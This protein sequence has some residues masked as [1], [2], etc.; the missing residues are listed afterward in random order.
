M[1]SYTV[2]EGP[3][4][5]AF[6]IGAANLSVSYVLEDWI[7]TS[8]STGSLTQSSMESKLDSLTGGTYSK[9]GVRITSTQSRYFYE[10]SFN[11]NQPAVT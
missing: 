1:S 8:S 10:N 5:P 9:E 7:E 11:F 2:D 3:Q 6:S 4:M